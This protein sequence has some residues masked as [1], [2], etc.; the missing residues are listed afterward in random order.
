M[1]HRLRPVFLAAKGGGDHWGDMSMRV[2][3]R[4]RP[5]AAAPRPPKPRRRSRVRKTTMLRMCRW[6][7]SPIAPTIA[8]NPVAAI[9][10]LVID[11]VAASDICT[12]MGHMPLWAKSEGRAHVLM[13]LDASFTYV[14][15]YKEKKSS[16]VTTTTRRIEA[17]SFLNHACAHNGPY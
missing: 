9:G 16:D 1:A 14:I 10:T 13:A 5:R 3:V 6:W 17:Y 4:R 2:A 11:T 12:C 8:S 7:V 15:L